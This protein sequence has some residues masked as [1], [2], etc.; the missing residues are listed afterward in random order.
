MLKEIYEQPTAVRETIGT[1]IVLNQKCDFN[2]ISI[3]KEYLSEVTR[4]FI[5]ACGT[6]MHAGL[7][8]KPIIEKLCN[9]PVFVDVA[10]EFRYREPIID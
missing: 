1:R 6:A 8:V 10:S 3:S 5:V 4:I 2:D 7:A 9:I